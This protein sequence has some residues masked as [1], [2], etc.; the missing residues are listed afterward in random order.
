MKE[1]LGFGVSGEEDLGIIV[2]DCVMVWEVWSDE[3]DDGGWRRRWWVVVGG[4]CCSLL[5]CAGKIA[6][7]REKEER[8]KKERDRDKDRVATGQTT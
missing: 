5:W 3:S 6:T 2:E 7:E 4:W 1:G 8:E